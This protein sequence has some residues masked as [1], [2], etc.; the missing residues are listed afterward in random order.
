MGR[1]D[2]PGAGRI[3]AGK[4]VSISMP[5]ISLFQLHRHPHL[6]MIDFLHP[7]VSHS[8][9][10]NTS[11]WSLSTSIK[12]FFLLMM[13]TTCSRGQRVLAEL[14]VRYVLQRTSFVLI[15]VDM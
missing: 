12:L 9:F 11:L 3:S 1:V 6:L 13:S 10:S 4:E 2:C 15:Y 8:I 14:L 5:R 7:R